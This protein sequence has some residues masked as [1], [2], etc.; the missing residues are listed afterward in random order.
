MDKQELLNLLKDNLSI[1]ITRVNVKDYGSGG[2]PY[3]DNRLVVKLMFEDEQIDYD[4]ISLK[5]LK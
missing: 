4:Y 2:R 5:D 3:S 1:N